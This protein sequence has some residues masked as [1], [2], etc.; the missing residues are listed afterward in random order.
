[1]KIPFNH[2]RIAEIT[3]LAHSAFKSALMDLEKGE[4]RDFMEYFFKSIK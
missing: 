4:V 1:M 3:K 2:H